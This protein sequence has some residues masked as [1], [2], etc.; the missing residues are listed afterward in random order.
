[1]DGIRAVA[2]KVL[3]AALIVMGVGVAGYVARMVLLFY[4]MPHPYPYLHVS[5]ETG[6]PL[7]IERAD[8][9]TG[10]VWRDSHVWG[11]KG[12]WQAASS[13]E[14]EQDQLV[15]RDL[16]GAVVARREGAC[17]SDTWT[18]TAEG[19]SAA[20]RYQ[21]EPVPAD[22]VEVLLR[23]DTLARQ[24]RLVAWWRA[25][26]RTLE[27]AAAA[28]GAAGVS[29]HGPFVENESLTMYL[30]GPSA[31]TVLEF[32][33]TQV[34]HPSPGAVYPYVGAPGQPAPQT[35]TSVFLDS[36]PQPTVPTL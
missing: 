34:L 11:T 23:L 35:G 28:G 26:P 13:P 3:R 32:A 24:D 16:Q 31:A 19:L 29:V 36:T 1:M 9:S 30:R 18:I 22:R 17:R 15:A 2:G 8:R 12:Y 33:R 27:G 5:N 14:C 7:L 4:K 6:R 25:L 21:R 10:G 20:P